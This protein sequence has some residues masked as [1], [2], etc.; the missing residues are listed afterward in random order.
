MMHIEYAESGV[1]STY[2]RHQD[3]HKGTWQSPTCLN[4]TQTLDLWLSDRDVSWD[5]WW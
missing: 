3:K 2:Q 1:C 5:A 4:H